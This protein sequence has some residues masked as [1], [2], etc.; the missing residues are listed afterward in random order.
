M[1]SEHSWSLIDPRPVLR[2]VPECDDY[3]VYWNGVVMPH[4][5]ALNIM[6]ERF[7]VFPS[8]EMKVMLMRNYRKLYYA[9]AFGTRAWD[10]LAMNGS[11]YNYLNRLMYEHIKTLI[12]GRTEAEMLGWFNYNRAKRSDHENNND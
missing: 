1:R 5:M 4:L 6:M 8:P 11:M 12:E 9:G 2:F 3:I 10:D 7:G